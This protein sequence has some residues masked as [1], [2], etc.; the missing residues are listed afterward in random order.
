MT[1]FC[2]SSFFQKKRR[3]IDFAKVAGLIAQQ[4]IR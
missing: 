2:A 1:L 4:E 3:D